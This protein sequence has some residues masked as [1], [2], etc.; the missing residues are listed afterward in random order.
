M[1]RLK[2]EGNDELTAKIE[3]LE[4]D[5]QAKALEN[6][7]LRKDHAIELAVETSGTTAKDYLKYELSQLEFKD[8][9]LA[10]LEEKLETIKETQP[11]LFEVATE[12]E[13][14][15]KWSQGGVSTINDQ[16]P[17]ETPRVDINAHRITN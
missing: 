17:L 8:G 6:E 15:K 11:K 10:G 16:Q 2:A 9:E 12:Q 1:Q 4:A 3:Q 7:Q 13:L 14:P 5:N